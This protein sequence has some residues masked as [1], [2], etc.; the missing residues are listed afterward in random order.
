MLIWMG[1]LLRR[2]QTHDISS[3]VIF[4]IAFG[5]FWEDVGRMR[6]D[7]QKDLSGSTSIHLVTV[8]AVN[9]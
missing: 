2:H 7:K 9:R 1:L 4:C 8:Q 6:V 5:V 3:F